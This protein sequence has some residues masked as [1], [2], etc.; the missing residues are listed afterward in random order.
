MLLMDALQCQNQ[1]R[2]PIWLMRQAGRYLPEYRA[3]RRGRSLLEMFHCPKTIVEVT[4]LPLEILHVD[5]AILFSDILTVFDGMRIRYDFQEN[6]GPVVFDSPEAIELRTPKE[7]YSPVIQG[8]QTLKK[9][10]SVPLL[11]FAGAPFTIASYLIEGRSSRDLKKTKQLLYREPEAFTRLIEQI[12][13]A[14]ISYLQ[15]Q[16]EA[17][18]DAVQLFD[19]WAN[20]LGIW[21]FREY[22]LKP[23]KRIIESIKAPAILFCRGS[24]L[25]ASE[26]A[27]LNPAAISIDWSGDLPTIRKSIPKTIAVQGNLDPMLLYGSQTQIAAAIDRLLE[28]M[29]GDPGYIFNLGHGLLPDIPVKNVKFMVDY[30]RLRSAQV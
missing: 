20:S 28:G 18:V 2:P 23:M 21:E 30:V 16:I 24:S 13:Q 17:G 1:G 29:R 27:S 22:C 25:F 4:E 10:L 12:T 19:S 11:G 6:I 8:I 15:C 3:M 26:L 9:R 7:A 14:T 5:A